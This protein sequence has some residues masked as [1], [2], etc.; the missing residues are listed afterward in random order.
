MA[1]YVGRVIYHSRRRRQ[2]EEQ[3]GQEVQPMKRNRNLRTDHNLGH[4]NDIEM[5]NLLYGRG[6]LLRCK[7]DSNRCWESIE[8]EILYGLY[9]WAV[10]TCPYLKEQLVPN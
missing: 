4:E 2:F 7:R 9:P 5:A 8:F 1:K 6:T 3:P 10:H